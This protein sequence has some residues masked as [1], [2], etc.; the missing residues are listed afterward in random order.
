MT[1]VRIAGTDLVTERVPTATAVLRER[2]V[3]QP[4]GLE[5]GDIEYVRIQSHG[6]SWYGWR[7]VGAAWNRHQL[8]DKRTAALALP[9]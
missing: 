7:P 2:V 3:R 4:D 1:A 6:A 9:R 8:T 5:L